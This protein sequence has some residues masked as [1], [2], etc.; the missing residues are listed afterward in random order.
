[1]LIND[2]H[3]WVARFA[4]EDALEE[5]MEETYHEEIEDGPIS[6]FATDQKQ[7]WYDHDL[8]YAEFCGEVGDVEP[9]KLIDC[10]GFP[11]ESVK[12]V[13][14]AIEKLGVSEANVCFVANKGEFSK[15]ISCK[16]ETYE[17]WY[18]GQFDGCSM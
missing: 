11:P 17:L 12:Q 18:V 4:S 14:A 2:A 15:G 7:N 9:R 5:Y 16:G 3:I 8:V 6:Q 10:W 13:L 1:M